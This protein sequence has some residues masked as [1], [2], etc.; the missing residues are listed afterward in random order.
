[1]SCSWWDSKHSRHHVNPNPTA[2]NPDIAVETISSLPEDASQPG[3]LRQLLTHSQAW[4][5]FPLLTRGSINL[6][7][8]GLK[9]L[10]SCGLVKHRW[11]ELC[12]ITVRFCLLLTA[13]CT[14][15]PIGMA[16]VSLACF[17]R[18]SAS[19]SALPSPLTTEAHRS[20]PTTPKRIDFSTKQ[21]RTSN[22]IVSACLNRL[23]LPDRD[24]STARS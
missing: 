20:A 5:F 15:M 13:V 4:A 12:L 17:W 10:R 6:R 3:E 16:L 7:F 9:H 1:M 21:V 2:T 14:L 18:S 11:T 8:Q 22:N 23:G 24:P 19:A